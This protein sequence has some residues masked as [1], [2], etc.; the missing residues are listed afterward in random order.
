MA[1]L[2]GPGDGHGLLA[3]EIGGLPGRQSPGMAAGR[4]GQVPRV[5]VVAEVEGLNAQGA[6]GPRP[7]GRVGGLV[8]ELPGRPVVGLGTSVGTGVELGEARQA[9]EP[10]DR[11]Q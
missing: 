11:D 1:V 9:A 2:A 5:V 4:L 10:G 7:Q 3:L 8:G 6:Q